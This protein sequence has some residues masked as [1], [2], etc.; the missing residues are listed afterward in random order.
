MSHVLKQPSTHYAFALIINLALRAYIIY[1]IILFFFR[2]LN[3][4][5]S[6]RELLRRIHPRDGTVLVAYMRHIQDL[7]LVS[8]YLVCSS[9]T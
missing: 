8:V 5:T 6:Y 9:L 4:E 2:T 3:S 7:S 1:T